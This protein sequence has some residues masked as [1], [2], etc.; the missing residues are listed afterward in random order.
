MI[1]CSTTYADYTIKNISNICKY[2][3]HIKEKKKNRS[4]D[5]YFYSLSWNGSLLMYL[6]SRASPSGSTCD[7]SEKPSSSTKHISWPSGS[8]KMSTVTVAL[9]GVSSVMSGLRIVPPSACTAS[10]SGFCAAPG[11]AKAMR[12]YALA[13]FNVSFN[14]VKRSDA[15]LPP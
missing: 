6:S 3:H 12:P 9:P 13:R 5:F 2:P 10:N 14:W 7:S 11:M 15:C 8:A 1:C 4:F